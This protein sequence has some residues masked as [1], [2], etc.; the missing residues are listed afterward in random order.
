MF[1]SKSHIYCV[2]TRSDN[3]LIIAVSVSLV[4]QH[5]LIAT[6]NSG[7]SNPT[8]HGAKKENLHK[9]RNCVSHADKEVYLKFSQCSLLGMK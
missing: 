6:K 8:V 1:V 3:D 4:M 2:V 7:M 9:F 5:S